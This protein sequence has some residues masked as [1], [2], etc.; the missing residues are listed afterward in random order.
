MTVFQSSAFPRGRGHDDFVVAS[1]L[2]KFHGFPLRLGSNKSGI[3]S[4]YFN[5]ATG[6]FA[7]QLSLERNAKDDE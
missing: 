1:Y 2:A 6:F 5:V 4:P 7:T 3:C